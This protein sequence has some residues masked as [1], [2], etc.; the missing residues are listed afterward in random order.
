MSNGN[1]ANGEHGPGGTAE[2]LRLAWPLV[3]SNS[4]WT[5]Q[6]ALDRILLSRSTGVGVGA[7]FS[8]AMFF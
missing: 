1:Q 6:I 5:L 3:L 2:L 7:A 8:A 4:F